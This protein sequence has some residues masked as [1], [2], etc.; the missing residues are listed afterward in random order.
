MKLIL[1][2]LYRCKSYLSID[3]LLKQTEQHTKIRQRLSFFFCR[4]PCVLIFIFRM[5]RICSNWLISGAI[6]DNSIKQMY[7]LSVD[8]LWWN[9][10]NIFTI[11][12]FFGIAYFYFY[13]LVWLGFTP[14][15]A[16]VVYFVITLFFKRT[17]VL[18]KY[19]PTPICWRH[20]VLYFSNNEGSKLFLN[21]NILNWFSWQCSPFP[22]C[23]YLD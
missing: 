9:W 15:P 14:N 8:Y 7:L 10:T 12:K 4:C 20:I 3:I 23:I 16:N 13:T 5:F 19:T 2:I 6:D 11:K 1:T 22:F 17:I 21:I 18:P